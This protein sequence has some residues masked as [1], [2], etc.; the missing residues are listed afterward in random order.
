MGSFVDHRNK[1]QNR[2]PKQLIHSLAE[3]NQAIASVHDQKV[4]VVI[5]SG[6]DDVG[7]MWCPD[8]VEAKP[9]I[10]RKLAAL[11]DPIVIEGHVGRPEWKDKENL[12][13]YRTG[14]GLTAVPTL[15]IFEGGV[16]KARLVEEDCFNLALLDQFF[17]QHAH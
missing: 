17:E 3:L 13:E 10:D 2:M 7:D 14:L 12:H 15:L 16:E 5:M 6:Y 8:S 4:F 1:F 9:L 11:G